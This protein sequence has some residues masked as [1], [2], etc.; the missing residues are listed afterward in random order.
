MRFG[1]LLGRLRDNPTEAT[2]AEVG[3]EY[4][5]ADG[6]TDDPDYLGTIFVVTHDGLAAL[7]YTDVLAG[8][9]Y[10]QLDLEAARLLDADDAAFFF[11]EL[12][13]KLS[14]LEELRHLLGRLARREA[15]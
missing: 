10:E 6:I 3:P 13:G 12:A 1:E 15:V 4:F 14:R 11:E 8:W 7:P 5:V 9:G 2:L